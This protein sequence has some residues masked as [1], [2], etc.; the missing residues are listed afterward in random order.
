MRIFWDR[1]PIVGDDDEEEDDGGGG[2]GGGAGGGEDSS[3]NGLQGEL[4]VQMKG[5]A[6]PHGGLQSAEDLAD[7]GDLMRN[8]FIYSRGAGEYAA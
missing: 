1:D 7:F 6:I 8:L 4:G 5:L 3:L 2:G